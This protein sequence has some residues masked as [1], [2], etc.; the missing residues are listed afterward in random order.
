MPSKQLN[1]LLTGLAAKQST[2]TVDPGCKALPL[3]IH[4]I[5][6]LETETVARD[7][8]QIIYVLFQDFTL[9]RL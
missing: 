9:F 3:I 7:H 8:M 6:T 1:V 5:H 4:M 2:N